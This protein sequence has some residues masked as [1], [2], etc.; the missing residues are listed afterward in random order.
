MNQKPKTHSCELPTTDCD[1]ETIC[2]CGHGYFYAVTVLA[3]IADQDTGDSEP[4]ELAEQALRV[5]R[6]R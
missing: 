1:G 5:I 3:M 2:G 6:G 4:H